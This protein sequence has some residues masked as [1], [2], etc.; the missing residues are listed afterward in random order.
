MIAG[1]STMT[2]HPI[3]YWEIASHDAQK[4][5]E[6]LEQAFDWKFEYDTRTTIHELPAGEA[7]QK[8][9]GGGVFTLQRAKLPFLTIYIEVDDID[10]RAERIENL[11]GHIVEPP[12]D[13]T[14][15]TRI[16]L[17]NE[18]S[19]VTLAMLERRPAS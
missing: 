7:A 12:F 14:A 4:T 16:C 5:V 2:K 13:A 19:G 11:G 15:N 1:G 10:E 17:F 8:F 3:V 9:A 6:F 18:P